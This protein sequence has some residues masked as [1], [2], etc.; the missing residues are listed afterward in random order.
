MRI[1]GVR[2]GGKKFFPSIK[3]TGGFLGGGNSNMFY[4][5]P[6][7]WGN[8]QIWRAY[9]SNGLKPPTRFLESTGDFLSQQ[10]TMD[11]ALRRAWTTLQSDGQNPAFA[12]TPRGPSGLVPSGRWGILW[13]GCPY[14]WWLY[15][16]VWRLCKM[17]IAI[18][19]DVKWFFFIFGHL[20]L[21]MKSSLTKNYSPEKINIMHAVVRNG[22]LNKHRVGYFLNLFSTLNNLHP[23]SLT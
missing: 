19:D 16:C 7:P 6:D 2:N 8:D 21:L 18:W 5:H 9:F 11:L 14:L 12:K 22:H 1:V 3:P 17:L 20:H 15:K 23:R 13:D 4:F 10:E